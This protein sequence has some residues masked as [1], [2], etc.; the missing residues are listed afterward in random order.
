RFTSV[1]L[2]TMLMPSV[3]PAPLRSSDRYATPSFTASR[4]VSIVTARP[5][6][7]ITPRLR[8]RTDD[9]FSHLRPPGTDQPRKSQDLPPPH[10][11]RHLLDQPRHGQTF[12][13]QHDVAPARRARREMIGHLPPHHQPRQLRLAG[14]P[15]A[16]A[17]ER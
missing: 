11:K 7:R 4:I 10:F 5:N 1:V 2:A 15:H 17:F 6:S 16:I 14:L 9:G 3:S 12:D 8:R 13:A